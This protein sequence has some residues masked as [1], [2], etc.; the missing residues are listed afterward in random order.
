MKNRTRS[1]LGLFLCMALLLSFWPLGLQVSAVTQSEID[2]LEAQRDELRQRRDNV[3][4]QLASLED[5]MEDML[6]RKS[7]LDEQSVLLGRDIELINEQ[8]S[9]YEGIIADK[10][11]AAEKAAA[12]EQEHY[13]LYCERVRDME[14][15]SAWSYLSYVLGADGISELIARLTDISDIMSYDKRLQQE[16][17]AARQ[18]A[19]AALAEYEAV[20]EAQ[21]QKQAELLDSQ[22]ELE[23][24]ISASA[25]IIDALESDI[26]SYMDYEESVAAEMAEVQAEIDAKAEELRKQQEAEEAKKNPAVSQPTVGTVSGGYYMWP[27]ATTYITSPFGPRVHPIYGQLKP[28]TGVDIGAWYGTEI[29]AAASGTVSLAVV[30]YSSVGYG[31]YVAIYHPNGTT[32]L[33]A[34][35]SSLAVS[36]GQ[37]VTQGQVIGYVGSTGA[38]NGPH[39]HFEIRV[40][41]ACVDPML[42]F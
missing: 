2:A 37:T 7:A 9:L 30:D 14:E 3:Q 19:D 31:T 12:E 22:T 26:D 21:R 10:K 8:I 6:E 39:I 15:N 20:Q 24:K 4:E 5:S 41:G 36:A 42:Y 29:Y 1:A 38:S 32:T 11:A 34:H 16:Y 33:Y 28:H 17:E 18:R 40:N 25:E 13:T 23:E 35:M 27:S